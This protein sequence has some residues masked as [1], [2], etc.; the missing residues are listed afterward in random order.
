MISGIT[1]YISVY[2]SFLP[3]FGQLVLKWCCNINIQLYKCA[4]GRLNWQV[5][6][7]L[8]IIDRRSNSLTDLVFGGGTNLNVLDLSVCYYSIII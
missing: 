6:N 3:Y 4:L 1:I 7:I 5:G 2:V 8:Y